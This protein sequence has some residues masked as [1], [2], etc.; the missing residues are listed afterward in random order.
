MKPR[1]GELYRLKADK[2]GKPRR[3]VVVS[4]DVLNGGQCILAIPFY[5][6]QLEKRKNQ[7]WCALFAAGEG[8][9]DCECVAKTDELSLFDKLDV[10]MA[11]GPIGRFNDDQMARVLQALKWSL[12]IS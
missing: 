1:R 12:G 3:I 7:D 10:D 9:L 2:V 5:S 6:Q 11:R 4:N 8:G